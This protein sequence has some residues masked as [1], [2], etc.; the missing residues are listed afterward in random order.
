MPACPPCNISKGSMGLEYWRTWLT[1][2]VTSLNSY[3]PI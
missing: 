2:H 1:G 3:H